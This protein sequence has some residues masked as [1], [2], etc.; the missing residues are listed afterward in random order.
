MPL[1]FVEISTLQPTEK[2]NRLEC[3][4]RSKPSVYAD[5]YCV[6]LSPCRKAVISSNRSDIFYY[7]Q[8]QKHREG[9]SPWFDDH[10]TTKTFGLGLEFADGIMDMLPL[11]ERT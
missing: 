3:R 6:A 4:L 9:L 1:M 7:A 5:R 8:K 10:F 11:L 2:K